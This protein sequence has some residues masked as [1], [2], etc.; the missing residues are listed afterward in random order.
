MGKQEVLI[1]LTTTEPF[2][3]RST[4][5]QRRPTLHNKPS[6]GPNPCLLGVVRELPLL[7]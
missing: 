5:T 4:T 1:S 6:H 3:R 7:A 2:T